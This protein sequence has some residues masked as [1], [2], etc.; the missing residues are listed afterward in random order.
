[1]SSFPDCLSS[2][3]KRFCDSDL[4]SENHDDDDDDNKGSYGFINDNDSV[5]DSCNHK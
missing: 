2:C 1:M 5:S 3:V 4:S